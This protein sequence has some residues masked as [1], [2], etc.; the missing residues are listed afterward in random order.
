MF[1]T[2]GSL[3][4]WAGSFLRQAGV[5]SCAPA[6]ARTIASLSHVRESAV[7]SGAPS[8]DAVRR[9]ARSSPRVD[10][11]VRPLGPVCSFWAAAGA[12]SASLSRAAMAR[13]RGPLVSSAFAM[14]AHG[15]LVLRENHAH[16]WREGV[17]SSCADARPH[18]CVADERVWRILW[19]VR[20]AC[21]HHARL[22]VLACCC[23]G[24]ELRVAAFACGP[25]NNLRVR[26]AHRLVDLFSCCVLVRGGVGAHK[27]VRV[28]YEHVDGFGHCF[29]AH[30]GEH[31]GARPLAVC[32]RMGRGRPGDAGMPGLGALDVERHCA[33]CAHRHQ[34]GCSPFSPMGGGSRPAVS[35]RCL[36]ARFRFLKCGASG[37]L[38]RSSGSRLRSPLGPLVQA[39][40][41]PAP[42]PSLDDVVDRDAVSLSL[43]RTINTPLFEGF[44]LL[45]RLH[46]GGCRFCY[47]R[48]ICFLVLYVAPCWRVARAATGGVPRVC[49]REG[50]FWWLILF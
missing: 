1:R 27:R 10:R 50:V 29:A 25:R 20:V 26:V 15:P 3:S 39:A 6:A 31:T 41:M 36:C 14:R 4:L 28:G 9:R 11:S 34:R 2:I 42:G 48:A 13:I 47:W 32:E 22:P 12:A 37:M 35:R 40:T 38:R 7:S 19:R 23:F 44:P 45:V 24:E 16:I 43:S 21:G 17:A 46:H 33:A 30:G 5:F 18:V 49:D 8:R